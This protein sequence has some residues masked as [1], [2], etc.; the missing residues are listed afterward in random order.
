MRRGKCKYLLLGMLLL[1]AAGLCGCGGSK[2]EAYRMIKIMTLEGTAKVIR[3]N[4]G[5]LDA[6][7]EMRLESGDELAVDRDSSMVLNL[8]DDK[9]VLLEPGTRMTLI[10]DGTGTDSRT[11]IQ[12]TEGAVVNQLTHELSDESSYEVTVPN[13]TM[14]VRGTVFRV[15]IEYDEE[16][17][18]YAVLT[19]LEG[20]VGCRLIFPDGTVQPL[21]EER[22]IPAGMQVR[23]HGD[24]E[25]SEYY[26]YDLQDI[27]FGEYTVEAFEFLN[28][29]LENG[30][31]LCI[32]EDEI[33]MWIQLLTDGEAEKS[34]L[35]K[36]IEKE[37][38]EKEEKEEAVTEQAPVKEM[39]TETLVPADLEED[40]SS[41][42]SDSSSSEGPSSSGSGTSKDIYTVTFTYGG[43]TFCTQSVTEGQTAVEPVLRPA[44]S[45]S[46]DFDFSNA[47]TSN[48][49]IEWK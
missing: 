20:K 9:Y 13:S 40:S 3:E 44:E 41:S 11:V 29:C 37:A 2:E 43:T 15:A 1:V 26:P 48:T 18:S 21:E 14:A 12:L 24:M 7:E 10:A 6:Y 47:I 32:T 17:D 5:E 36:E 31:D 34:G 25:I 35:P 8:D 28:M 38:L 27:D 45:G 46:W 49:T 23:V 16:G 42:S 22:S 19:V 4:V 30:A 39:E 33:E